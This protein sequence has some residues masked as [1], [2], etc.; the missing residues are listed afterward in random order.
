MTENLATFTRILSHK[1]V[2]QVQNTAKI[3]LVLAG[4]LLTSSAYNSAM[5]PTE[6]Q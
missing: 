3:V 2:F 1:A 6:H 5:V 4:A